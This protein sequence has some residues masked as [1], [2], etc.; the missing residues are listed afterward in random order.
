MSH[1]QSPT[2]GVLF[3]MRFGKSDPWG[4]P[5]L[6]LEPGE[7]PDDTM[8]GLT[9]VVQ[10]LEGTGNVRVQFIEENGAAY[11]TEIGIDADARTPQKAFARFSQARWGSYSRPDPDGKLQPRNIRTVLVGINSKRESRVRMVVSGLTWV[12]F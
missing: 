5:R 12:R 1:G 11:L 4:Y 10:V 3:E 9:L 8:D 6:R 7:I 2:G